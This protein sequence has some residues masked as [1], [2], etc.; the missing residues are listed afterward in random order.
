MGLASNFLLA[1]QSRITQLTPCAS[2]GLGWGLQKWRMGKAWELREY[3]RGWLC[4]RPRGPGVRSEGCRDE[5]ESAGARQLLSVWALSF[6]HP[7][8]TIHV[9]TPLLG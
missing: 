2:Q 6:A 4:S 3:R 8:P 7:G 5:R 1:P 9:C